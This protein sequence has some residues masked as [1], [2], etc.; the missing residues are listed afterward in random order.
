MGEATPEKLF[1]RK[2][3]MTLLDSVE[4]KNLA[5]IAE[6]KLVPE[7]SAAEWLKTIAAA[8]QFAHQRGVLHRDLKPQNIMVDSAGRPVVMDFG[9]A[10]TLGSDSSVTKTGTVMGRGMWAKLACPTS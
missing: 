6:G 5:Q 8:V 2:W 1:E 9:L 4:G 7:R 10:K 3:A